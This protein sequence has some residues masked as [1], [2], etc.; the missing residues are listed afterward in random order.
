MIGGL[1]SLAGAAL[2]VD[3]VNV[4]ICMEFKMALDDH[5]GDF[6]ANDNDRWARG[7]EYIA[8][9]GL[10]SHVGFL[11]D[12]TGCVNLDLHFIGAGR[13]YELK[14]RSRAIV[15]G[16]EI[17]SHAAL[18]PDWLDQNIETLT[19]P[20]NATVSP[21]VKDLPPDTRWQGLAIA[22]WIFNRSVF[23]MRQGP[24]REC[25][26]D[27]DANYDVDGTCVGGAADPANDYSSDPGAIPIHL[28]FDTDDH[29]CPGGGGN[30]FGTTGGGIEY[31]GDCPN[32]S[33]ITHEIGHAVVAVRI[34]GGPEDYDD[35]TAELDECMADYYADGT[36]IDFGSPYSH[37]GMFTKE[38][39]GQAIREGWGEF[40]SAWAWNKT[41]ETDCVYRTRGYFSDFDLDGVVD[42]D[43]PNASPYEDFDVDC[44]GTPFLGAD[45]F[46]L[47]TDGVD[48]LDDLTAY[49]DAAGCVRAA[50]FDES[51]RTT[52]YDVSRMFWALA[53]H[54]T[55]PMSAA[56]LADFYVDL[57]PRAWA[58][59]DA[60]YLASPYELPTHRM[61]DSAAAQGADEWLIRDA[62][63]DHVAH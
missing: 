1:F 6:W 33:L 50:G 62:W 8:Q 21:L 2:A 19:W 58:L 39:M 24:S 61:Y 28:F 27:D 55:S 44:S 38:Y 56:E 47:S 5:Y 3:T 37:R 51:N 12:D 49:P 36:A 25:C 14:A 34:G 18:E 13:D 41:I 16:V 7:V 59:T 57:C 10:H 42:N 9:D 40:L 43:F 29:R 26:L 11:D 30:H 60:E 45:P 46:P 48:W 53:S 22:T 17:Q 23:H 52:A 63:N 20:A 54:P 31:S 32:K 4:D 15:N 35:L